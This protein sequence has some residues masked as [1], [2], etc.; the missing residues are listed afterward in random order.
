MDHVGSCYTDIS[1]CRAKN[2]VKFSVKFPPNFPGQRG[3]L[4]M[5]IL[6]LNYRKESSRF[7]QKAVKLLHNQR[8]DPHN[9]SGSELKAARAEK[10]IL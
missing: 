8:T 1:R 3:Y 5:I 10:L 2:Y 7:V 4:K 9:T 6:T